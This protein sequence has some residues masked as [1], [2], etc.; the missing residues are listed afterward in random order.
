MPSNRSWFFSVGQG[1]REPEDGSGPLLP[2]EE[3]RHSGGDGREPRIFPQGALCVHLNL[4]RAR[5][6]VRH[7]SFRTLLALLCIWSVTP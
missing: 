7:I 6:S 3:G 1:N 5:V 2:Q 4:T